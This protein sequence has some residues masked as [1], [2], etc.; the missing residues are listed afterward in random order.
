M[1]M[2]SFMEKLLDGVAVEWKELGEVANIKHGKDWKGLGAGVVP[3]Y[4]R[5]FSS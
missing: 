4:G 3:V 5:K 2:P 1:T